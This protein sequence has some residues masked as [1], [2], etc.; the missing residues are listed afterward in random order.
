MLSVTAVAKDEVVVLPEGAVTQVYTLDGKGYEP[1]GVGYELKRYNVYKEIQVAFVDDKI[2]VQGLSYFF[3]EAWVVGTLYEDKAVFKTGQLYGTDEEGSVYFVGVT[4]DE[5]ITDVTF[6]YYPLLGV[7]E[8]Q[9]FICENSKKDKIGVFD[10]FETT[11]LVPGPPRNQTK[12]TLPANLQAD[13]YHASAYN[14]VHEKAHDEFSVKIAMDG[15]DVYLQRISPYAPEAWIKGTLQ[16]DKVTFPRGQYLGRFD[17]HMY[18]YWDVY[19][20]GAVFDYDASTQTLTSED[21]FLTSVNNRRWSYFKQIT[22]NKVEEKAGTPMKPSF[23]E[24]YAEDDAYKIYLGIPLRTTDGNFMI[25]DKLSYQIV[26]EKDDQVQTFIFTTD[27]YTHLEEE[28]DVIPYW[29]SDGDWHICN[30]G[31]YIVFPKNVVDSWSRMGVKTIYTGGGETHESEI[32][33]KLIDWETE[34]IQQ[35]STEGRTDCFDLSGRKV[36]DSQQALPYK[37][38]RHG[39]GRIVLLKK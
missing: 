33:W 30:R 19:F 35:M 27:K 39:N 6:Y 20:E 36:S 2:Y 38:T 24:F 14:V 18:N 37:K 13:E 34:G 23:D 15:S 8:A 3:P 28:M 26:Y 12:V 5:V 9:Q 11:V 17:T 10:Y 16:D 25:T 7:L 1:T 22:V 4:P 21:G 31:S 29:F 32:N